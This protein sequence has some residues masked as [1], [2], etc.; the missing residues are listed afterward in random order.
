MTARYQ[1]KT[2]SSLRE[3][4]GHGSIE[5]LRIFTANNRILPIIAAKPTKPICDSNN[6][7][8][9]NS[10]SGSESYVVN[11]V[12]LLLLGAPCNDFEI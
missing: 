11:Y 12:A 2:T 4:R 10:H 8:L 1:L 9:A 5:S 3:K 7:G 6:Y